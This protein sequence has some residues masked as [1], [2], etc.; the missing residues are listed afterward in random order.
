MFYEGGGVDLLNFLFVLVLFTYM[1]CSVL[2][3]LQRQLID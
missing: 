1:F 2:Y 3:F